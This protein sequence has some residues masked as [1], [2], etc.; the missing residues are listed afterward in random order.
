MKNLICFLLIASI[1]FTACKNNKHVKEIKAVDSLYTVIDSIEKTLASIDTNNIRLTYKTYSENINLL[2]KNFKDK[3]EDSVWS[4]MTT[5]GIIKKPLKSFINDYP[6]FYSEIEYSRHQ[7]DSL[8]ID[9]NAGNIKD[10]KIAEYTKTESEAVYNLKQQ[11][12]ISVSTA[13]ERLKLYD[14]LNPKVIK[15]IAKLKK[16]GKGISSSEDS[17][18]DEDDD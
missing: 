16:E 5:Y 18:E 7:L 2:K 12:E 1:G 10:D 17:E 6:D 11:V 13:K 9:I 8:K 4:V 15:V 3:K 14:S